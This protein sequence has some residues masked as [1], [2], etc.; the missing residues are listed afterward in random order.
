MSEIDWI[1]EMESPVPWEVAP[2]TAGE[3]AAWKEKS[4]WPLWV[5]ADEM[6]SLAMQERERANDLYLK[7]LPCHEAEIAQERYERAEAEIER[8]KARR[9]DNC[10]NGGDTANDGNEIVCRDIWGW[11]HID[12]YCPHWLE[13]MP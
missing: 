12:G 13:R 6:R 2:M 1:A 9:C 10:R 8:L 11:Q 3:I 5:F 7:R 4:G